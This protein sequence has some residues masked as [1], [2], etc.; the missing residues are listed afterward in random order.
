MRLAR[1]EVLPIRETCSNALYQICSESHI[2]GTVLRNLHIFNFVRDV[3]GIAD[4]S[5]MTSYILSL[6][7]AMCEFEGGL[8]AS[9]MPLALEIAVHCMNTSRKSEV[10]LG[11]VRLASFCAKC[12][13]MGS[14]SD[15]VKHELTKA[16]EKCLDLWIHDKEAL[17]NVR[18]HIVHF[19]SPFFP[20]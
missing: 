8:T 10:I 9:E 16:L 4:E 18:K 19:F 17:I 3:I 2:Y 13:V 11:A 1:A 15:F 7:Y 12:C 6:Q 5:L 20:G 14:E